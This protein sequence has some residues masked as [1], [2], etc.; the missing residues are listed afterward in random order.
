MAAP[1]VYFYCRDNADAYQDDVV[2]LADGLQ[3]LG[4]EV[5]SSC[6]YWRRS[7]EP[8]DWLVRHDPLIRPEDCDIVVVSYIWSRW[9]NANFEVDERPIPTGL[10]APGRRYHTVYLDYDDGY[11]TASWQ[12]EYRTFDAIFRAKYNIRCQHPS[13]HRPWALGISTRMI[14]CTRNALPWQQRRPEVLVN[15]GASH[16]YAHGART[17]AGPPFLAAARAHFAINDQRDDLSQPPDNPYDRLMWE[18]TQHRHSHAYYER[19]KSAQAIVAFC[20]E[21]I[22]PTPL[23]PRYLVGGRRAKIN[24]AF[25]DALAYFDPRPPRLIQ[26]DSWRFWEGLAAGCLVFNLDLPYYGVELPIMPQPFVHYVPV[27][28]ESPA[29]S[30]TRLQSEPGLAER[31]ASQGHAWALEHYAPRA[32]ARRFLDTMGTNGLSG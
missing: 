15:F 31:I 19:L 32:L 6:N 13:N 23:H 29:D 30:L 2:V 18:Q 20:G 11:E 22:P 8:N 17:Q 9:I 7:T 12:P 10:F 1:R 24:R 27:R 21:L 14:S 3:Q 16:P 26:W 4:C 5:Y 28:I 25:H